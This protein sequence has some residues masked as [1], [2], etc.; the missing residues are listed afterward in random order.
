MGDKPGGQ[1]KL[2]EL[3]SQSDSVQQYFPFPFRNDLNWYPRLF[4]V[5][6]IR[7]GVSVIE[8]FFNRYCSNMIGNERNGNS[9]NLS[10]FLFSNNDLL[11]EGLRP[12]QRNIDNSDKFG[13]GFEKS[14]CVSFFQ[15]MMQS[16]TGHKILSGGI[17]DVLFHV[18]EELKL[19]MYNNVLLVNNG[20]VENL[21]SKMPLRDNQI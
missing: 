5:S 1:I 18:Q 13:T 19:P 3:F 14:F 11:T 10:L 17:E 21:N 8:Q 4:N 12:F 9:M 7:K 2:L 15:F 16:T 20:E 6:K